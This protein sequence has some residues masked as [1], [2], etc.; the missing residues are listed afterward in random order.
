MISQIRDS[1]CGEYS[2]IVTSNDSSEKMA[3]PTSNI[4]VCISP[5][6]DKDIKIPPVKII[7]ESEDKGYHQKLHL[8][9]IFN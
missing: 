1:D 7:L 8:E 2:Y 3:N 5:S 4:G 9:I 6:A